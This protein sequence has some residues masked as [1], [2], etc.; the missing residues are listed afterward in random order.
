MHKEYVIEFLNEIT[1]IRF[2]S[3]PNFFSILNAMDEVC[4][5]GE[6][7]LKLWVSTKRIELSK[8]EVIKIAEYGKTIWETP[9][10]AAFVVSD[11]FSFG[12]MRVHDV[13]REKAGHE[14]R[15]FRNEQNAI[16]W[17]KESV[18]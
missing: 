8:N 14:T 10:K 4:N 12:L 5:L 13:Y 17:L 9:S 7:K 3:T 16:S 18:D 6:L 1:V 11:D 15:V 2:K